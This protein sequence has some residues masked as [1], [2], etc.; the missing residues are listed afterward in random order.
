[1]T[2]GA[3]DV[4]IPFY[5]SEAAL[6]DLAA[7]L[8]NL[9]LQQD[10]SVTA[11]D[12]TPRTHSSSARF[13]DGLHVVPAAERQ[14]SYF[15]RNAGARAN[16]AEWIVFIDAD[17]DPA[18]D[19]VDRYLESPPG[20]ETGLLA[21]AIV[22]GLPLGAAEEG[23]AARYSMRSG[24]MTQDNTL[25]DHPWSYAQTANCA[26]R[27]EAFEHV[28]G[29]RDNVRSG[30]DADLAFRLRAAGWGI[31]RRDSA[32]VVHRSRPSVRRLLGQRARHGSGAAWLNAVHPGSFPPGR[33]FG[34][35]VFTARALLGAGRDRLMGRRDKALFTCM[36]VLS[37]WA[38]ELGRAIPNESDQLSRGMLA[39][40]LERLLIG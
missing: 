39:R 12:N 22:D 8:A 24:A 3:V 30:G 23:L 37:T 28:G 19:L 14:S 35:A 36:D 5:G 29:F 25:G 7:R 16:G 32:R 34:L 9:R 21:G 40:T 2:R 20:P 13:V 38:F 10:D 31:E 4:V 11:V 33:P 6:S 1:M 15:A 17:V 18:P 27:R 26:V